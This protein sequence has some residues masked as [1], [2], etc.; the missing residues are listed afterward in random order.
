MKSLSCVGCSCL[1][2]PRIKL[3]SGTRGYCDRCEICK[4]NPVFTYCKWR[5]EEELEDKNNAR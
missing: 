5:E 3:E 2:C 1:G 4:D